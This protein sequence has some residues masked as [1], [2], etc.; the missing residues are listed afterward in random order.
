MKEKWQNLYLNNLHRVITS[1]YFLA[2]VLTI[3]SLEAWSITIMK[4]MR[5]IFVI[6]FILFALNQHI[7]AQGSDQNNEIDHQLNRLLTKIEEARHL[8]S[9]FSDPTLMEI[10]Q[11][12]E[13]QCKLARQAYQNRQN[14]IAWSHIKLGYS[15]L[16]QLYLKLKSNA[17]FR[18]KFRELLDQ[19]I[20][21]AE[22]I[23]SRSNNS[24]ALKLLNRAR[25]FRQRSI[26]LFQADR[27]EAMLKSYLIAIFFTNNAIRIASGRDL[28][29]VK[30]LHRHFENTEA[31]LIQIEDISDSENNRM[32]N[33]LINK[34]REEL[35]NAQRLYEQN[36]NREAFQKLQ[37]VN[38][39]LYRALDMLD[40]NPSA[41]SDRIFQQLQT[42]EGKISELRSDV[43]ENK[44]EEI[45]RIFERLA[46]LTTT[47][48]QKYQSNDY[49]G[50]RQNILLAN[51]LLYQLDR[52][53]QRR[54]QPVENQ[55]KNQLQTAEL[56]LQSLRENQI[57]NNI[58]RKLL[59]I[60]EQQ[61]QTANQ[62]YQMGN[63]N[64]AFQHLKF[65]N[66]LALKLDQMKNNQI[67]QVEEISR[68]E[69]AL[70]R[71]RLMLENIPANRESDDVLKMKYDYAKNLYDIAEEARNQKKYAFCGQI[72]RLATNLITQ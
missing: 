27:P 66:S 8:V 22:Q 24:E 37:M 38:R 19:K 15:L 25:Y 40:K 2:Q 62:A 45:K 9:L 29:Q 70:N 53:L 35:Q 48:R 21:E 55:I 28:R 10:L 63:I 64:K 7:L 32:A 1:L 60:L 6:T 46:F 41:M 68:I 58:Y 18:I 36:Q 54:T 23:V 67:S 72:I 33:N 69:E 44:R 4:K 61:Y 65:F 39:F 17:Y 50:A 12:A 3:N 49:A 43:Q 34:S 47:A 14:L 42:L 5:N 52:Q 26:Q 56:M 59:N 16:A 13:T 20:Q 31:L 57:D 30:N 71:L 51:R 11:Q